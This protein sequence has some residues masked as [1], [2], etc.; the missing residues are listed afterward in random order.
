MNIGLCE[1]TAKANIKADNIFPE[2][3]LTDSQELCIED[4]KIP[5]MP[6]RFNRRLME[7]KSLIVN[8]GAVKNLCSYKSVI[9]DH[10]NV[11]LR[12]LVYKELDVCQW[13]I[14]DEIS[15]V[16]SL[17]NQDSA[18]LLIAKMHSGVVCTFEIATT[19]SNESN[20]ITRHEIV[21]VEGIITDRSINEQVPVEA[22]YLFCDDKKD[23]IG[24]TDMDYTM[25]GLSPEEIMLVDNA[26]YLLKNKDEYDFW[27]K[28]HERLEYLTE[29]VFR[30]AE[31]GEKV[32]TEV[33]KNESY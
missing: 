3:S 13:L 30:S 2:W 12:T 22:V 29:C 14:G 7:M 4:I 15:Y 6:W 27:Q 24:Y 5:L 1:K 33:S 25:F 20:P 21:G 26:I 9:V 32:Y 16:Y 19:L 31:L 23:P 11:D 8:D 28:R 17:K 10:K 18:L